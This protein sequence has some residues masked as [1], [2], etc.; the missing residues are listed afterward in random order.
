MPR[1]FATLL[2][3]V[4]FTAAL[5]FAVGL[6]LPGAARLAAGSG[7]PPAMLLVAVG[8]GAFGLSVSVLHLGRKARAPLA[9]RGVGRSWLSREVA[10]A[11]GFVALGAGEILAATVEGAAGVAAVAA[12]LCAAC[13][14][15]ALIAIGRVYDLPAQ[16]GWRGRPASFAPLVSAL[17]VAAAAERA[18]LLDSSRALVAAAAFLGFL[19]ADSMLAVPRRHEL[20]RRLRERDACL[21]FPSAAALAIRLYPLRVSALALAAVVSLALP[22]A[23]RWFALPLLA[24][25]VLHD[26]FAFYAGAACASPRVSL[27]AIRRERLEAAARGG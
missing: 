3:L 26:R 2:P 6:A 14:L 15:A 13:G 12:A 10:F 9:L 16:F 24:A 1:R 21:V 11:V 7:E 20:A 23:W 5:P 8:V 17:L 27:A 19:L 25:V 22:P 4:A 18:I